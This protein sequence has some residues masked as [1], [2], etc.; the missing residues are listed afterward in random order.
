MPRPTIT[1]MKVVFGIDSKLHTWFKD[2]CQR[3][4]QSDKSLKRH[5]EKSALSLKVA[6]MKSAFPL[7]LAKMKYTA[8]LIS[9]SNAI[10]DPHYIV[11]R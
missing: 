11:L 7:N 9:P 4:R 1:N 3:N 2:Y 5:F 6:E 8:R 10:C